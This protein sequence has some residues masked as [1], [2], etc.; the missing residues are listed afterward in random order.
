[1]RR[2]RGVGGGSRVITLGGPGIPAT[3]PFLT[4]IKQQAR[5]LQ[6]GSLAVLAIACSCPLLSESRARPLLKL[7]VAHSCPHPP[8]VEMTHQLQG[9]N[10]LLVKQTQA[11]TCSAGSA[12]RCSAAESSMR[13]HSPMSSAPRAGRCRRT[14]SWAGARP[15]APRRDRQVMLARQVPGRRSSHC[16]G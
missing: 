8:P 14:D 9:P 4:T 15:A 16:A 5:R 7:R 12:A 10:A 11:R 3:S 1:M 2:G 13:G 6:Q